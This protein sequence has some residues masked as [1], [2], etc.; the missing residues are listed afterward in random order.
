MH[1]RA[2]R[3]FDGLQIDNAGFVATAEDRAQELIYFTRD[4]LVDRRGRFFSWADRDFSSTG[5]I[6]QICSLTSN[7]C[8]PNSR[9]R[10]YSATSRW[11]L[12]K[13]AGEDKVSVTVLPSTLR[14]KR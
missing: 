10:W 4:F 11:A 7:S 13:L 12:A 8:P 3:G 14:V 9:K 2:N 6:P 5:R 1:R